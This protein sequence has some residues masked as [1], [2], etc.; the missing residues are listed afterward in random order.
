L[1]TS[2]VLIAIPQLGRYLDAVAVDAV[3]LD[4]TIELE[5]ARTHSQNA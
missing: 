1:A 3:G 2:P 4:W 5:F